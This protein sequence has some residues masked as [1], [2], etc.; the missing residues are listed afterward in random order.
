MSSYAEKLISVR[1]DIAQDLE[2]ICSESECDLNTVLTDMMN[3]MGGK[4]GAVIKIYHAHHAAQDDD[5]TP[6]PLF[7]PEQEVRMD[8][9]D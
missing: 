8:D 1:G 9:E 6:E 7:H 5:E 3:A 4:D 2:D